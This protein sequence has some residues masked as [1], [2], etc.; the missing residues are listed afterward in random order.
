MPNLN[1]FS[2]EDVSQTPAQQPASL[3]PGNL[4]SFDDADI[5]TPEDKFATPSQQALTIAEGAAQGLGGPFATAAERGLSAVG[6]P[7]LTPAEQEARAQA[8]PIERYGSEAAGFGVGAFFGTGEAGILSKIG[9][10]AE[11]LSGLSESQKAAR[12]GVSSAAE[13]ASLQAGNEVSKA[14][15][16]D[17]NQTLG[18][19]AINIGLAGILGGAGG[20]ALGSVGPLWK[21]FTQQ[22]AEDAGVGTAEVA[23]DEDLLSRSIQ[24]P[25]EK[26]NFG[27][28]GG[29]SS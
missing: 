7:G 13:V 16:Q 3:P 21:S 11:A 17:P 9:E 10:G 8:N 28:L 20:A 18:S 25:D 24:K 4:N 1:D 12:L 29:C 23:P 19:A 14:I 5:Q 15:N 26:E 22:A 6:V 2:P 27:R